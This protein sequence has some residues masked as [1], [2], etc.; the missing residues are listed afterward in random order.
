MAAILF[1]FMIGA[2]IGKMEVKAATLP[3]QFF[4]GSWYYFKHHKE[5]PEIAAMRDDMAGLKKHYYEKG[6]TLGYSPCQAF[7]PKEYLK[8]NPELTSNSYVNSNEGA[9]QHFVTY[10]LL[11][12][13]R[14]KTSVFFIQ[15]Y[16]MVICFTIIVPGE[17][18]TE[19]SVRTA[20]KQKHSA[21]S[22]ILQH[23]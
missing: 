1:V 20:G 23:I 21:G 22:I 6:I 5:N 13:E 16:L 11:G 7:D 14:R 3:E 17:P 19:R 12:T 15:V 18:E 4:D 9:Y 2:A 8:L 10:V